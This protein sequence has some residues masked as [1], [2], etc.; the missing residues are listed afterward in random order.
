MTITIVG[1]GAI[2]GT[3]GAYLARACVPVRLVDSD[4]DHIAA[5]KVR[6]LTLRGFD[7][8]FTVPVEVLSPEKLDGPLDT[9]LL[10]VGAQNAVEAVRTLR[11]FLTPDSTIVSLQ[12]GLCVRLIANLLGEARTVACFANVSADYL[13]PGLISYTGT[14]GVYVGELDGSSSERL[15]DIQRLLS[16]WST[17]QITDNIWGHLWGKMGYTNML[18]ATA[19]ADDT[20][21]AVIDRYRPLMVELATEIYEVANREGVTPEPFEGL[22]PALYFPRQSQNPAAIEQ[23]IDALVERLRWDQKAKSNI[24]RDLAVRHR[25]TEVEQQIELAAEVGASHRLEM[26]L[27]WKLVDMI[28]ELEDGHRQMS[29]ENLEE[30]DA[31]R[32]RQMASS[33]A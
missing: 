29:W 1:A 24:W 19:L 30:L 16:Y 7:G 13:E 21:A 3:V 6:G 2:G 12:N 32:S 10:A 4:V 18:F 31:I 27:T 28:H 25:K 9:V 20:M 22:H 23:E 5:M 11:P 26:P 33:A 15:S 8:T 17:A 14:K